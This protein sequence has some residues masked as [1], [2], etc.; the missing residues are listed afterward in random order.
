MKII[1]DFHDQTFA[2]CD[3][4]RGFIRRENGT[5]IKIVSANFGLTDDQVCPGGNTSTRTCRSKSSETRVRWNCSE[6]SSC[7]LQALNQLFG[8]PC[9]NFLKYLEVKYYCGKIKKNMRYFDV[10]I[11]CVY[12]FDSELQERIQYSYRNVNGAICWALY[13]P[14]GVL[15]IL[16]NYLTQNFL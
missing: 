16:D 1:F 10:C 14:P 8:N 4:Q 5:K 9:A 3:G 11:V 12:W 15:L 2:L 7:D 13:F 6:Y